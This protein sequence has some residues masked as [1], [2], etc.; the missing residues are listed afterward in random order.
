MPE[1][2]GVRADTLQGVT[3][4]CDEHLLSPSIVIGAGGAVPSHSFF[5]NIYVKKKYIFINIYIYIYIS[6]GEAPQDG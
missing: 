5:F 6:C 4:L 2:Y 3:R 1:G